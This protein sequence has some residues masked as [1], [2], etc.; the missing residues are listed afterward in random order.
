MNKKKGMWKKFNEINF[1]R[2]RASTLFQHHVWRKGRW[3]PWY[4]TKRTQR[5]GRS[6]AA[7][8]H[9]LYIAS[10]F[11]PL[12]VSTESPSNTAHPQCTLWKPG[13]KK[14]KKRHTIWRVFQDCHCQKSFAIW[15]LCT[16]VSSWYINENTCVLRRW[17]KLAFMSFVSR[18]GVHVQTIRKWCLVKKKRKK[19]IKSI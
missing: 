7:F 16:V 9:S 15:S 1:F 4:R 8:S 13:R 12:Q 17:R 18:A 2:K 11:T 3:L 19:S 14:K 10:A 5:R 6:Y